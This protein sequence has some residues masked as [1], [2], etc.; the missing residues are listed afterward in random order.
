MTRQI[1]IGTRASPLALAQT[2]QIVA[3]LQNVGGLPADAIAVKKISTKGDEILDRTLAEIG[4]KGLFTDELNAGLR[5]GSIDLAVHSLKDLP[6]AEAPGLLTAAMPTREDA[7]ATRCER[8]T[9]CERG[10]KGD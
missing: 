4:G 7:R 8:E 6:T 1:T 3:A 2:E 5:D 9:R 10:K